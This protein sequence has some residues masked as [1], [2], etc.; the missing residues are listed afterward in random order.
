M[1]FNASLVV[2]VFENSRKILSRQTA[3]S[4]PA[5]QSFSASIDGEAD[6][7][8]EDSRSCWAKVKVKPAAKKIVSKKRTFENLEL[9]D[10][11]TAALF[12]LVLRGF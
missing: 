9:P 1:S 12:S 4:D 8:S 3:L 5:R 6:E 10:V 2:W 7:G 11:I